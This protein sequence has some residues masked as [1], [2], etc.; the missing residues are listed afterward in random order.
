MQFIDSFLTPEELETH[1]K[2]VYPFTLRTIS[3]RLEAKLD[4]DP[5]YEV[6]LPLVYF[7]HKAALTVPGVA[8]RIAPYKYFI[9]NKG[10]VLNLRNPLNPKFLES[11]LDSSGYPHVVITLKKRPEHLTIHRMIACAFVEI[12]DPLGSYH[13]RD[14]IVIHKDSNKTNFQP[15]NLAWSTPLE[16]D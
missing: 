8:V 10:R 16:K 7:R 3:E 5:N 12:P 14:L 2:V 9:S 4:E 6:F 15:Y 1:S 11:T 13:P